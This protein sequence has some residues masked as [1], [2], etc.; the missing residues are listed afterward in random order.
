MQ[1]KTVIE[2]L[3][4]EYP[5]F[6]LDPDKDSKE[7]YIEVVLRG[8]EPEEMKLDHYTGDSYDRLE[9]VDTPVGAVKVAT[10]ENRHDFELVMR[11]LM[12]AKKGPLEPIPKSQGAAMVTAINWKKIHAY[13][14]EFPV[15]QRDVEFKKFTSVKDNY[16]D[17]LVVLSRG[18]YSNVSA[19]KMGIS[20]EKWL[21]DS[22]TIRRYHELTHVICRRSCPD[23]IDEVRDELVADAIGL[24]AAY[25]EFDPETEKKFLGIEGSAYVGGRLENYTDK[26]EE[27]IEEISEKLLVMQKQVEDIKPED[28]FDLIPILMGISQI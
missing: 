24:Y 27:F 9:T 7:T 5:L 16:I 22:D 8:D 3:A 25:G 17:R 2:E 20:E 4:N 10:F 15:E 23:D 19:E 26:P 14:G 28:P 13:L 21:E 18:P 11:G 1:E 6:Y 12:A